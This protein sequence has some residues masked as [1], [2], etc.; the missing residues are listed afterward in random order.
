MTNVSDDRALPKVGILPLYLALYDEVAPEHREGHW[1]FLKQLAE[2]LAGLGLQI[3]VAKICCVRDEVEQELKDLESRNLDL[4]TTVHLAY[5]PS[6]ESAEALAGSSLPLAVLDTTRALGFGEDA[7]SRDMMENHGIHGVQDLTNLLIRLGK[8]HFVIV[9]HVEDAAFLNEVAITARA[10]RSATALRNM[11]TVLLGEPFEGMGDF[12]VDFGVLKEKLGPEVKK[13][14]I[15]EFG[16]IVSGISDDEIEAEN[17]K[18]AE[19]FDISDLPAEVLTR[20]NRVGLA[21]RKVLEDAGAGAF[22][23]NFQSFDRDAGTPTVPFLE[24]SK[25]MARGVGYA[26]EGDVL[27]ASVTGALMSGL[28]EATFTE[29]FCPDWRENSV[30]MSHMGEC[31]VDLASRKPKLVEK[32]YK[33]GSTDNPAVAVFPLP[34]RSCNLVN[35]APG[36]D[37]TF[38][39]ICAL[40]DILPRGPVPGFPQV[41]HFWIRPLEL[42]IKRFLRRYSECGG[43]HHLTLLPGSHAEALHRLA[44]FTGMKFESF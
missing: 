41:P 32:D 2:N 5:S 42:N 3:E 11:K 33:Y 8:K 25:A 12:A 18:D 44:V 7:T 31:N 36:P 19:R 6:L 17:G 16:S 9:G 10:A 15:P 20:S 27:T 23:M 26:G 13:V 43:T 38:T 35:V 34:S 29:M 30:F 4:L 14:T 37:D 40:V 24:A 28:G 21:V 39:L 22:T 1:K